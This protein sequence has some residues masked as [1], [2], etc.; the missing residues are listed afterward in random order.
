MFQSLLQGRTFQIK[1]HD[2]AGWS[3]WNS[4]K[5][6][7]GRVLGPYN[8]LTHDLPM[9]P[10]VTVLQNNSNKTS[11]WLKLWKI[12]LKESISGQFIN[13]AHWWENPVSS[14]I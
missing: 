7:Q 12:K 11:S 2:V 3:F 5:G 13:P 6:P 8:I 10:K 1:L 14:I 4:S 9:D